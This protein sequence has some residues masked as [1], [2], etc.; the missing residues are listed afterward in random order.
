VRLAANVR[1][2]DVGARYPTYSRGMQRGRLLAGLLAV[3]VG[4]LAAPAAIALP[5]QQ[6]ERATAGRV[7]GA[8]AT[9]FPV[10]VRHLA[11]TRGDRPLLTTI[12]YPASGT[13]IAAGTFPIV[14]LSHGL[15]A[16]PEH[17]A[18]VATRWA[19]AGFVVAAPLYPYTNKQTAH[20]DRGDVRN[21]PAD[22]AYVLAAVAA[23]DNQPGD[24]FAGH[25]DPAHLAAAGHSAG[26]HTTA[27]MFVAGHPAA[28]R[29][30]IVISGA[31]LSP[32][33]GPPSRMLYVHGDR[34]RT[35][36]YA[37]GRAA[38]DRTPWSKAFLTLRRQGH[39]E[40]LGPG[41]RQFIQL[42]RVTT[43]FLRWTLY[44]DA[45]ARRRLSADGNV[46]GLSTL[47]DRL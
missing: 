40:F 23:L 14:L 44:G 36:S 8:P 11:L 26:G 27:G 2:A 21:Q 41:S 29:A 7:A 3:A 15:Y 6:A 1:M 18:P 35:V 17:L 33:G 22:A 32:F 5:G 19:S 13:G 46:G 42:I 10:A 39:G 45:A 25:L 47:T 38:F 37:R 28:L 30:G 34:D 24:L 20:F 31:Q 4:T 43:D 16:L 12:W 9:T